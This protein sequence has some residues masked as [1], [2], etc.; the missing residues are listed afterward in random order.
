MAFSIPLALRNL[1]VG[2][3]DTKGALRLALCFFAIE[4]FLGLPALHHTSNPAS[5][6]RQATDYLIYAIAF[7]FRLWLY[8][9]ALE[10]YVRRLWPSALIS[11]SRILSGQ[12]HD[13]LVG[14]ELLIGCLF[15]TVF[16]VSTLAAGWTNYRVFTAPMLGG[17]HAITAVLSGFQ[18]AV[19]GVIAIL[20]FLLIFRVF[21][22]RTWLEFLSFAVAYTLLFTPREI[23]PAIWAISA[24]VGGSYAVLIVRFG[25]L[26]CCSCH[27][28]LVAFSIPLSAQ[29]TQWHTESGMCYF[30]VVL[31]IALFGYYTSTIAGRDWD[32]DPLAANAS[33]V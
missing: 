25:L 24:L 14:R 30:G 18:E 20:V 31:I 1:R 8:Y 16:G 15:G 23:T 12:I 11:S 22:R 7:S 9:M 19:M 5:E 10:P 28:T 21:L 6:I 26:A 29:V 17:R 27:M 33:S 13:P 3:G 4:V 2:R 32:W